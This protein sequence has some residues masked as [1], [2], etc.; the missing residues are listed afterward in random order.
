MRFSYEQT[1]DQPVSRL[2]PTLHLFLSACIRLQLLADR[3]RLCGLL[4]KAGGRRN[5]EVVRRLS[6]V[7]HPV[8]FPAYPVTS[9]VFRE[10]RSQRATAP[11]RE[12]RH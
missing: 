5:S 1:S 12:R 6:K 3:G 11:D 9:L 10:Q 7:G 8:L 4:S 2:T